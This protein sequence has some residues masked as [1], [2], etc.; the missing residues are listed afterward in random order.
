MT[1]PPDAPPD[2]GGASPEPQVT[3]V[4]A[5]A[6]TPSRQKKTEPTGPVLLEKTVKFRFTRLNQFDAIDPATIHLHWVQFVQEA[7]GKEIQVFTNN[8]GIM[9]PIDTMRWTA[10]QHGQQ[11]KVHH[12]QPKSEGYNRDHSSR[13]PSSRSPSAFIMH[14]IRT[15]ATLTSIRNMPRVQKL[16]RDNGVYL[17]EHR[18]A[19]DIHDISQQ[20]F[21]LGIDP[22]FYSP[23]Q[24]HAR[25]SHAVNTALQA[26]SSPLRIPQFVVAFCTPQVTINSAI[27]KTKAYAIETERSK[28]VE[29]QRVLKEACKKTNDFIP[30][31]LRAKHPE[32]F[33]RFIQHHTKILSQNHTIVLNY[34]SNQSI[35]YLEERIRAI[36]GVIDIVPCHSVE[37]DG[38]FRVQVRK[39]DFYRVRSEIS[40][41]LTKWYEECVPEDAK[42]TMTKFPLPPEVA[43]LMSDGYS[44]GSDGYMTASINTAMSYASV[45]SNLTQDSQGEGSHQ[46]RS[47]TE[48]VSQ[49]HVQRAWNTPPP[50]MI[51]TPNT[52][53]GLVS[54]LQ[55]SRSE[56]EALKVQLSKMEEE[57]KAEIEEIKA[58]AEKQRLES[59]ARAEEQNKAMEQQAVSQRR[60]FKQQL[61]DQRKELEKQNLDRQQEMEVRFQ[62]QINQAIQAHITVSPSA[63]TPSPQIPDE[64]TRRME[65]QDAQIQKLTDLIQQLV[66]T[67]PVEVRRQPERAAS[68]GK[69]QA[70][71]HEVIDLVIDHEDL[72]TASYAS[73]RHRNTQGAKKQDTKE[74]PRQD[75]S[76]NMSIKMERTDSPIP[77]ELSMS[78]MEPVS[79]PEES[80]LWTGLH[81]PSEVYSP[82]A[83]ARA[84]RTGIGTASP[85]SN[86][87]LHP[88]FC[89]PDDNFPLDQSKEFVDDHSRENS[90]APSFGESKFSEAQ[91]RDIHAQHQGLQGFDIHNRDAERP[92]EEEPEPAKGPL[93]DAQ[94]THQATPVDGSTQGNKHESL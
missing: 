40:K 76:G 8:G 42:R 27:V 47:T 3:D 31:H 71:S 59:E 80:A 22:Q 6:A 73:A 78:M 93:E 35:F 32:A 84:Y 25:I 24:A 39:D 10:V 53:A 13:Q 55:S 38:K 79:Q 18:W 72:E 81:P 92:Q 46:K 11:Y 15:S 51:N 86:L 49:Q 28:S 63:P 88:D 19:E 85:M 9:P 20:G 36:K 14:R 57:K 5:S 2:D 17:T 60:E 68:T 74:T 33:S 34:I 58:K 77:S 94:G 41:G 70:P 48:K 7:L 91:L 50:A 83:A 75:L 62:A 56:V 87:A 26:S 30:F 82:P 65:T 4:S 69:R 45:V 23:A 66:T 44:S 64:V 37:T 54:E 21:I 12:Q 43:P 67:S 1:N 89:D 61:E 90:T 16:L 52:D 29:M